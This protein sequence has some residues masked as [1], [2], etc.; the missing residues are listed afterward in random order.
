MLAN[1]EA[2]VKINNVSLLIW[3]RSNNNTE[4]IDVELTIIKQLF[5]LF[6]ITNIHTVSYS[7]P[8]STTNT[9]RSPDS[10][11]SRFKIQDYPLIYSI[12][13]SRLKSDSSEKLS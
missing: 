4:V 8:S 3:I 1:S 10:A 2:I 13:D 11:R 9:F 12:V 6:K 5:F 7:Q